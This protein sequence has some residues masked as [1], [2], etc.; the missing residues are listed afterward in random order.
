[1]V[2]YEHEFTVS[3]VY[4]EYGLPHYHIISR[5][6]ITMARSICAVPMTISDKVI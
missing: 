3:M 5:E 6:C 1:M 4:Y 2:Y